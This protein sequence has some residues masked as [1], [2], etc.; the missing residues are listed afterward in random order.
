MPGAAAAADVLAAGDVDGDGLADLI[1]AAPDAGLFL[2]TDHGG[3]VARPIAPGHAIDD[4]ALGDLD[5]DGKLD[6]ALAAGGDVRVVRQQS[7][8]NFFAPVTI[9]H[10]DGA[11]PLEIADVDHDGMNDVIVGGNGSVDVFLRRSP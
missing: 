4:G 7:M 1:V 11:G 5:G 9:G 8:G 3:L 2:L 6:I 10:V